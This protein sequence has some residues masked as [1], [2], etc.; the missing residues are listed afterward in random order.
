MQPLGAPAFEPSPACV[1]QYW[2]GTAVSFFSNKRP[3][4]ISKM[5]FVE[6]LVA[7]QVF[8][9]EPANLAESGCSL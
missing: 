4:K 6:I 2:R 3:A 5:F 8:D 9:T 1:S 7:E